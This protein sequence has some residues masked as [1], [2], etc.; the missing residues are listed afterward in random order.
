MSFTPLFP[1]MLLEAASRFAQ[2]H[3]ATQDFAGA[4]PVRE[5]GWACTMVP[6]EAGGVGGTLADLASI[7]TG[8]A[9]HGVH[10]PV[11]ETCAVAPLLLQAAAPETAALWLEAVCEGSAK[12]APLT[13]LSASLDDV[14]V[15]AKQLDIGWALT[16]EGK[17]VDVSLARTRHL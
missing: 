4:D 5:M 7:V 12:V 14:V 2:D 17:R 15:Q 6:E 9:T 11:V 10:L 1:G 13:S 16:G 8:L 3:A